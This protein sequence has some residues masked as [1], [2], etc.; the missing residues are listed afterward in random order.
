MQPHLHFHVLPRRLQGNQFAGCQ[1]NDELEKREGALPQDVA[2]ATS[3][4][5]IFTI[6]QVD[7][8]V[9]RASESQ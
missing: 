1:S 4:S 2:V 8:H 7:V 6:L 5:H 3:V 9:P